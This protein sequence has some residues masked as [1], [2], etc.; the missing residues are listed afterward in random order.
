LIKSFDP[1]NISH[2]PRS[3]S[4]PVDVFTHVASMITPSENLL[5]NTL[6]MKLLYIPSIP[7]NVT[8]LRVFDDDKKIIIFL[9]LEDTF[10]DLI[11]EKYQHDIE[12]NIDVLG[13]IN[14]SIEKKK[15]IPINNIPKSVIRL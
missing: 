13:S 3:L 2:V 12:L 5:P 14:Q 15:T 9:H 11:I 1:F 8:S 4:S 10:K 7:D 6:S